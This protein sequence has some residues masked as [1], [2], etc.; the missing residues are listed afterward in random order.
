LGIGPEGNKAFMQLA[1]SVARAEVP[2]LRTSAAV[3]GLWDN[4][5]K[6]AGWQL[7]SSMIHGFIGGVQ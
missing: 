7:S 5:K 2:L 3:N 4:L 6:T 1:N